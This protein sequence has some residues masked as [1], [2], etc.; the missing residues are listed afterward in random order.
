MDDILIDGQSIKPENAFFTAIID[1][2]TSS[3][4]GPIDIINQILNE[5]PQNFD[6]ENTITCPKLTFVF[7]GDEYTLSGKE[8]MIKRD[9]LNGYVAGFQGSHLPP[10][11]SG[12]FILGDTFMK[13]FF[14][15]FDLGKKKIGFAKLRPNYE[16]K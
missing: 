12:T 14:T 16:E 10:N 4:I 7:Q 6:C 13:N 1:S 8:Y 15:H 5:I 3:I 9:N 2:G 11:F